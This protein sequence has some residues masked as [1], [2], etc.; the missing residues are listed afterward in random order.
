M[1]P[2]RRTAICNLSS[3]RLVWGCRR[4]SAASKFGLS[5]RRAA[6]GSMRPTPIRCSSCQSQPSATH[7]ARRIAAKW[8]CLPPFQCASRL[9]WHVTTR[10]A[11]PAAGGGGGGAWQGPP[12][13]P[14][15]YGHAISSSGGDDGGAGSSHRHAR[16]VAVCCAVLGAAC[17]VS[18]LSAQAALAAEPAAQDGSQA[19]HQH[20]HQHQGNGGE[21]LLGSVPAPAPPSSA[22]S[23]LDVHMGLRL[24]CNSASFILT[25]YCSCPYLGEYG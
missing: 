15:A 3:H 4:C 20:Q 14:P 22:L 5:H 9:R 23:A 8:P 11:A 6:E 2:Y 18:A 1:A 24:V 13:D 21:G 12:R 25:T 10:A 19:Q 16:V 17:V 7:F